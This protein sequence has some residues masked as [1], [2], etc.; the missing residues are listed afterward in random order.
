M[1]HIFWGKKQ[2]F[3]KN[4]MISDKFDPH[5]KLEETKFAFGCFF[6]EIA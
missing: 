4:M 6:Q 3:K 1:K 2:R 5:E